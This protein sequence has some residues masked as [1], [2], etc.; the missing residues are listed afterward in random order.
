MKD[1]T[2]KVG[3]VII[4]DVEKFPSLR[5]SFFLFFPFPKGNLT[6]HHISHSLS[7]LS[8]SRSSIR[9]RDVSKM[10]SPRFRFIPKFVKYFP[11]RLNE[12]YICLN[13]SCKHPSISSDWT[14]TI[15]AGDG[16]LVQEAAI[17]EKRIA[18][19]N[20]IRF[21]RTFGLDGKLGGCETLTRLEE[22]SRGN[23]DRKL[24]V[25]L[26]WETRRNWEG[27]GALLYRGKESLSLGIH[28][29]RDR[30]SPF[31][32]VVVNSRSNLRIPHCSFPFRLLMQLLLKRKKT[33]FSRE[34]LKERISPW[35]RYTIRILVF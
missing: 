34:S 9:G 4:L 24:A 27:Q 13:L 26:E 1:G 19:L 28:G 23:N 25:S 18:E 30:N 8:C 21:Y 22:V 2:N 7:P 5:N 10:F 16:C 29:G 3:N 20:E 14:R 17:Y 35:S 15:E 12:R 6:A 11:C 31:T 32:R 33:S